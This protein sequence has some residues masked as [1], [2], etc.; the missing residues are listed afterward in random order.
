MPRSIPEQHIRDK[1]P[2]Q[3]ISLPGLTP[4]AEALALQ[5]RLVAARQQGDIPD[6]L[7]F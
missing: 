3:V 6:T 4:Y 7:I 1:Q 5:T 2:C